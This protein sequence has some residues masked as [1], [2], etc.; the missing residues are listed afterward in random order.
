[1]VRHLALAAAR[2]VGRAP[3]RAVTLSFTVL[4]RTFFFIYGRLWDPGHAWGLVQ[5]HLLAMP[6]IF[7]PP[8]PVALWPGRRARKTVGSIVAPPLPAW[9][10]DGG[11]D[12]RVA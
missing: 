11:A 7:G 10:G 4:L 1:M 12:R 6:A 2:P 5:V 8:L 3:W 9:P